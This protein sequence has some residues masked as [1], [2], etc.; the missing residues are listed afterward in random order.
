MKNFEHDAELW[1]ALGGSGPQQLSFW[2][3]CP[4]CGLDNKSYGSVALLLEPQAYFEEFFGQIGSDVRSE[5]GVMDNLARQGALLA[6]LL[7]GELARDLWSLVGEIETL[8][9]RSDE[10]WIPWELLKLQ[11]RDD[12]GR[13]SGGPF[14]CDAF[15]MSRWPSSIECWPY[16]PLCDL[17]FVA[18]EDPEY[19]GIAAEADFLLSLADTGRKVRRL[20]SRRHEVL[21]EMARGTADG[22]HFTGHGSARQ[23]DADLWAIQLREDEELTPAGLHGEA[24]NLGRSRP[25][26]F[27]NACH[28]GRGALSLTHPGGWAAKMIELGAGAFVG[29]SWAVADG[30]A[31]DMARAFYQRFLEGMPIAE[32]MRQARRELRQRYPGDAT[33]LAYTVFAHPLA[34]CV[35]APRVMPEAPLGPVAG[36]PAK[37]SGR[38][39]LHRLRR[40]AAVLLAGL[41]AFLI[42]DRV[43]TETRVELDLVVER[44]SFRLAGDEPQFLLARTIDWQYLG[45]SDFDSVLADR[46]TFWRNEPSP[47]WQTTVPASAGDVRL[48]ARDGTSA[49]SV[50]PLGDRAEAMLGR[51][52]PFQ[53]GPEAR[54]E[55]WTEALGPDLVEL[56]FFVSEVSSLDVSVEGDYR[57]DPTYLTGTVAGKNIDMETGESWYGVGP[58][59]FEVLGGSGLTMALEI[60][61]AD[62]ASLLDKERLA[63]GSLGFEKP[64]AGDGEA[65]TTL[66]GNGELRRYPSDGDHHESVLLRDSEVLRFEDLESFQILD[67]G[68]E[69]QSGHLW[70]RLGG[71]VGRIVGG[72]PE[73]ERRYTLTLLDRLRAPKWALLSTWLAGCLVFSRWLDHLRQGR[74]PE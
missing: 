11:G 58:Q 34:R 53:V 59:R 23:G 33:W 15:A 49:L 9:L 39:T 4:S 57:L 51:L 20:R 61:L 43:E 46:V 29:T 19:L 73:Q 68:I 2:L 71:R 21:Q 66:R 6:E 7:P 22:W 32:A 12:D 64:A 35:S 52:P 63:I 5:T 31:G 8:R 47:S 38:E 70:V 50:T 69:A 17:V 44:M 24:R 45:L 36:P 74:T 26:V 60:E 28:S 10:M 62:T 25:L 72:T 41:L 40:T 65:S 67:L 54:V 3:T 42:V 48:R 18:G 56:V 55:L 1:V 16:L 30:P 13:W 14:L 27:L 37:A